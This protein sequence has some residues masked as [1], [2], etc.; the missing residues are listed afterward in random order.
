MN[1]SEPDHTRL[2]HRV[3]TAWARALVSLLLSLAGLI[4]GWQLSD[5]GHARLPSASQTVPAWPE[6]RPVA[7]P[8]PTLQGLGHVP[9]PRVAAPLPHWSVA[10]RPRVQPVHLARTDLVMLGRMNLDG[11]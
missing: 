3:Q 10:A 5:P 6:L 7:S 9:E 1:R 4:L 2:L 11:G 8:S